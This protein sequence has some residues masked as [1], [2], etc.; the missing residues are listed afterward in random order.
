MN[1]FTIKEDGKSNNF[2]ITFGKKLDNCFDFNLKENKYLDF[3]RFIK[4]DKDWE[5]ISKKN[6]KIFY[7][8]DLKLIIEENGN[9]SLEKD[10]VNSYKDYLDS[11]YNGFRL[12]MNT[13]VKNMDINIF[14]GL[15]KI[16]DIRKLR[17]IIFKKDN[18]YIKFLVVNHS[19]KGIT[20][21]AFIISDN[22]KQL[23]N[24]IPT[25]IKYFNLNIQQKSI[26]IVDNTD[27]LSISVI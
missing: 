3:L 5:L 8:Y 27:N 10:I 20:F 13:Q 12:L 9:M 24:I 11:D 25:F 2:Q 4:N 15:N 1:N 14:P 21:E 26:N 18:V 7:Y 22:T 23:T 6:I 17:E 16:H 19:N